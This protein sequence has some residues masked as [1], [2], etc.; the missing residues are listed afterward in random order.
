MIRGDRQIDRDEHLL[1]KTYQ[2]ISNS[3]LR[4]WLLRELMSNNLATRD[5]ISFLKQQTDLRTMIKSVDR[6]TM[7]H[8]MRSKL[9]DVK[10]ALSLQL[11]KRHRLE[12]INK[13]EGRY[14]RQM[15][16]W[17]KGLYSYEKKKE[18]KREIRE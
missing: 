16:E 11:N 10:L 3:R 1:K 4:I 5:I 12:E 15:K 9:K 13:G 17:R 18:E 14:I 8:A 2:D 7:T 6:T